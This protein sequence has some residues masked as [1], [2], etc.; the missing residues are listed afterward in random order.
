M[1]PIISI[2]YLRAI[3][4]LM[5]LIFHH[6]YAMIDSF[7]PDAP[8]FLV[9]SSG[10]D[11][12]F[13]ISGFI[14]WTITAA[15]PTDPVTFMKRRIIRIVPLYWAITIFTVYLSTDGGFHIV[16]NPDYGRF[17]T[18][19][20]FIPSWNE[21][22]GLVAPDVGVGWTLNLEMMFYAV[23]A[24]ALF[25]GRRTQLTIL[26]VV[27]FALA[28]AHP[29]FKESSNAALNL[30]T[31]TVVAEF[32]FGV[33]LG[34]FYLNGF[35][36]LAKKIGGWKTGL[37]LFLL[38]M[39]LL[40]YL[41]N[42][43]PYRALHWGIPA[44]LVCI[45]ALM[46]EPVLERRPIKTL[47]FLGDASYSLYLSHVMVMAATQAIIGARFGP[48]NPWIVFAVETIIAVI[49]GCIIH[50]V[51]EKPITKF[52]RDLFDGGPKTAFSRFRAKQW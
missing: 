21:A 44:L 38:G 30:Y 14:M 27:L 7:A 3:A 37:G 23:F 22:T 36:P 16:T 11:I 51:I 45:G 1:K 17:L 39:A 43:L 29:L 31:K 13:V 10:V 2:Q 28:F 46:M 4:A 42:Y 12:F 48:E 50:V 25:F 32:G 47:K 26:G 40:P 49:V 20:F 24:L 8:S 52:T 33:F 18:S 6:N 15:R 9:L 34:W 35:T 19:L 5:V 41:S